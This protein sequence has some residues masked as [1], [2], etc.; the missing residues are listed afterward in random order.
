M[1]GFK[2]GQKVTCIKDCYAFKAGTTGHVVRV[3]R[4]IVRVRVMVTTETGRRMWSE[5]NVQPYW[6]MAVE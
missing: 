6:L 1:S 4:N 2:P 5:K 3:G